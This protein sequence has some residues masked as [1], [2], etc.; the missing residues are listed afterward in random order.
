MFL[1]LYFFTSRESR[2]KKVPNLDTCILD[3][4][5]LQRFSEC[6]DLLP[7]LLQWLPLHKISLLVCS[8]SHRC[9]FR[10]WHA[11]D[12]FPCSRKAFT[13]FPTGKRGA[14]FL[15][16][17]PWEYIRIGTVGDVRGNSAGNDLR[18]ILTLLYPRH[19]IFQPSLSIAF[20]AS[21]ETSC[22]TLRFFLIFLLALA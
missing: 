16:A 21:F 3:S 11:Q 13:F 7:G 22:C 20:R 1:A 18:V 8:A 4:S 19:Y 15:L 10:T 17:G 6:R 12:L 9:S 14:L 2:R 5:G